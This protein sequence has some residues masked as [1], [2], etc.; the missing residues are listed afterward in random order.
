MLIILPLQLL[1]YKSFPVCAEKHVIFLPKTNKS[2]ASFD[3][4]KSL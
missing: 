3:R 1:K 2:V 4:G